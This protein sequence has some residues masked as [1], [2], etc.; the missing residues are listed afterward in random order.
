MSNLRIFGLV[1]GIIGLLAT[2]LIYRGPKW[3]R[4]NFVLWA[5]FSLSLIAVAVNPNLVDFIRNLLLLK[6]SNRGR[7]IALLILSNIFLVFYS[8]YVR[9]QVEH[10][11]IQFDQLVRSL[12]V[13]DFAEEKDIAEKIKPIMVIIPAYNEAE[14]LIELLPKIPA[15]INGIDVGILV[16][17]DG[18][19]DNTAEMLKK[20]G[21]PVVSGKINRGQG[22]ASRLGYDILT[23][24]D[25]TIGVTMD[26]DNQHSPD[27]LKKQ[28]IPIL[29]GQYDLVIGSRILG[30]HAK[31]GINTMLNTG[32][33]LGGFS[34]VYGGGFPPKYIPSFCWGG[35]EGFVEYRLDK[36]LETASRMMNR[37]ERSLTPGLE[38]LYRKIFELTLEKRKQWLAEQE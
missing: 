18:S 14:N 13:S 20:M 28:V 8:F 33:V 27:D 3:K 36:A 9:A 37:R 12:G 30:D 29:N 38:S 21:C 4:A 15:R 2:F 16:V 23:K 6:P 1:L 19:S 7:I 24:Y 31:T 32:S 35:K 17:N 34:N 11:R 10:I 26:A 5:I 25:V 22:A